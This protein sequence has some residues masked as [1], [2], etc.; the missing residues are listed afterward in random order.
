MP[1]AYLTYHD[2]KLEVPEDLQRELHLQEGARLQV[3]SEPGPR[4]VLVPEKASRTG[5]VDWRMYEGVLAHL[6]LDLNADLEA[7][8][9]RENES[10]ERL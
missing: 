6:N 2:G 5:V 9:V 3:L 8:R 10:I 1:S 7:E 4:L